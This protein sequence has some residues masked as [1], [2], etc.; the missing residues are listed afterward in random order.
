MRISS[1][2]APLA[3]AWQLTNRCDLA[4]RHCLKESG[5]GAD[6]AAELPLRDVLR[7][8]REIVDCGVPYAILCGG[9]PML[10]PHFWRVAE[11]LGEAGVW[12]KVE[13]N[14][15]RLGPAASRKLGRLPIRSVQ[16]S[17]D[18]ATQE[19]YEALRPGACLASALEAC[20]QVRAARMP[21]EVSFVP[22]RAN[23]REAHAVIDAALGLGAFRFNTGTLI[24]LGRASGS[25]EALAPSEEDREVLRASLESREGSLAGR[26]ELCF[27]PFT[28]EEQA[29]TETAEPSGTLA[30]LPDG[31]VPALSA[32]G[33][34]CADLRSQSLREAW[35]AYLDAAG[36]R[37]RSKISADPCLGSATPVL[38]RD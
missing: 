30:I 32:G 9:E 13:T 19:A 1:F 3:V 21:L 8:C 23:I 27:R 26:M 35:A 14:G 25:W 22:T 24:R 2:E 37:S 38:G 11:T 18:G 36:V 29:R 4:C 20:R 6:V 12:L 33:T 28:F 31:R 17:L 34:I 10:S 7:I 5:P 15:Q 16:V